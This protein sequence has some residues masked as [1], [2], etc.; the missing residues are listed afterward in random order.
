[1]NFWE[2]IQ[3][4]ENNHAYETKLSLQ[5]I[6][7]ILQLLGNPQNQL[8]F[9]HVAGTNGKGSTSSF[10]HSM[11]LAE[12]YKVGLFTSPHLQCYT[13]RIRINGINIS[14]EDFASITEMISQKLSPLLAMGM[15]PP[16]MFDFMVLMAFVY[17]AKEEVDYVILEV[18]LGGLEDATNVINDS[19]ASVITPI[20]IDH[21][22]ILGRDIQQIAYH[23]AGI[24]RPK[25]IVVYHWQIPEVEYVI[26]EVASKNEATLYSLT[27]KNIDIIEANLREQVFDLQTSFKDFHQLRIKMLGKHQINNASL[28]VLTLLALKEH[29]IIQIS[30]ESIYHGLYNNFWAGRLELL[31]Q[32]PHIFIDGAH[33]LQ[34]SEV[35]KSAIEEHF[36]GRKINMVIGMLKDK[37]VDGVLNTLMPLCNKVIFTRPNSK[38]AIDPQEL[39]D[40]FQF[41]GKEISV[42]PSLE[43][44]VIYGLHNTAPDEITIYTGSLY[45]IGDV[46]TII[47]QHLHNDKVAG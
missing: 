23:K 19:L 46:K 26:Q 45:L 3:F 25:G 2:A 47:L 24:I 17:Y 7:E 35:L 30:D 6:K 16:A 44:A 1:M 32:N 34:G 20:G 21:I 38:R 18:G 29:G 13:D 10:L 42:I 12:G 8:K 36:H 22:D 28:A 4:I 40:R 37:D 43:E 27:T 5:K 14:Q 39:Y 41:F 33:N 15:N 11:L 9:I 31:L